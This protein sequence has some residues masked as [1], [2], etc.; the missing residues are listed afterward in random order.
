[1]TH[2]DFVLANVVAT[3]EPS[4]VL[5]DW[6]GSGRGPRLWSLAFLLWAE[7]SKDLRRVDLALH[8]YTRRVT[9]EPEELDRL[10][11]AITARPLVL[12]IWRLRNRGLG[13]ADAVRNAAEN[14][15]LARAIAAHARAAVQSTG[16]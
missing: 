5:V 12:D 8:G 14:A 7:G 4:M 9:L 13:A 15:E 11:A 1:M 16:R 3:R 10:A 6:A 2:P